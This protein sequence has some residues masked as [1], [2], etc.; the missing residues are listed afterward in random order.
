MNMVTI[1]Q[2]IEA[3]S[4]LGHPVA[5]HLLPGLDSSEIKSFEEAAGVQLPQEVKELYMTTGG[6]NFQEGVLLGHGQLFNGFHLMTLEEV[7]SEKGMIDEMVENFSLYAGVKHAFAGRNMLPIFADGLGNNVVVE[8]SKR[9]KRYGSIGFSDHA[10]ESVVGSF[11][12]L[13]RLLE[14]HYDALTHGFYR[15]SDDG[16]IEADYDQ[17]ESV[18]AKYK[19][20]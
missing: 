4:N 12:S 7:R 13:N 8:V 14:A 20:R 2:Y 3:L 19:K 5:K 11:P 18:L 15:L 17:L 10:G 6:T 9:F 1:S 16:Y